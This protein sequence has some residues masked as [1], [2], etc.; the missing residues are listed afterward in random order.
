MAHNRS[1]ILQVDSSSDLEHRRCEDVA[2]RVDSFFGAGKRWDSVVVRSKLRGQLGD[3]TIF[4]R[5]TPV[6][7]T[8][9]TNVKAIG[10]GHWLSVAVKTDGTVWTWGSNDAGDLGLGSFDQNQHPTPSQVPGLTG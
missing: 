4:L 2:G 8:G 7:V 10:A 9:L 3:G 1:L 6:K 5:P